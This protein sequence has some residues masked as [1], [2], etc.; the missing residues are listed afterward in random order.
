MII[1]IIVISLISVFISSM[2]K[3]YNQEFSTLVSVTGGVIIFLLCVDEIAKIISYFTE[4]YN[5][6]QIDN[7]YFSLILK[8]IG[9]GYITE[10]TA[11]I[12]E[13]FDNKIV[14]SRVIIGGKI[15]IC[16]MSLPVIKALINLLLSFLY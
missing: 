5:L 15:V 1:K 16:G 7:E 9:I 8:I 11:D 2:L 14:A 3:K 4:I 6:V 10:F 12:A 13:D